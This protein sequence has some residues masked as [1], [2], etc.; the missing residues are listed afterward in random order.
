M[1][2]CDATTCETCEFIEGE[3]DC[4]RYKA[5]YCIWLASHPQAAAVRN[6][7]KEMSLDFMH[8]ALAA[9]RGNFEERNLN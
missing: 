2:L 5:R 8:D 1:K 7:L 3:A 9:E 6:L 4:L